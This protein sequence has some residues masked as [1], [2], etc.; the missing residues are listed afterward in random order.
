MFR[1][2]SRRRF[3]S[4]FGTSG[5][6]RAGRQVRR[7]CREVLLG[8]D[9]ALPSLDGLRTIPTVPVISAGGQSFHLAAASSDP[10]QTERSARSP[11]P[12]QPAFT[13]TESGLVF[14]LSVE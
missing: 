9:D 8:G 3:V 10:I 5:V 4:S 7:S 2:E 14:A 12:R 13:A 11:V 1:G 6:S